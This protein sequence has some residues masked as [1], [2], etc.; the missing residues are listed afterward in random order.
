MSEDKGH[1][2]LPN[3]YKRYNQSGV[4]FAH[5]ENEDIVN[6]CIEFGISLEEYNKPTRETMEKIRVATYNKIDAC[7]N[8]HI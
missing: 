1:Y 8:L 2:E 5:I 6:F 3:W 4:K 7:S